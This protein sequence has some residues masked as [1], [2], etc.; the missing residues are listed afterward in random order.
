M[1]DKTHSGIGAYLAVFAALMIL[2]ALTV[3]A[4]FQHLG[5]WNTPVALAVA[6][7]KAFLVVWIFMHLRG[8]PKLTIF[9]VSAGLLFLSFL[10]LITASD[11]FTRAWIPI[12]AR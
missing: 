5:I 1:S 3:W 11:Y 12:Y 6:V 8:S 7:T 9:A 2:T 4:A 10:I